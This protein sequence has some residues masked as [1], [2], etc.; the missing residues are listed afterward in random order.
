MKIIVAM[1]LFKGCLSSRD[2]ARGSTPEH[3]W[4]GRDRAAGV[5]HAAGIYNQTKDYGRRSQ[6]WA[7]LLFGRKNTVDKHPLT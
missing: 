4:N 5:I 6:G 3:G 1:D 2:A 7:S